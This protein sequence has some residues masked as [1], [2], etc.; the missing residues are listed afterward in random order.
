MKS[1]MDAHD[2]AQLQICGA[3][4]RF[5]FVGSAVVQCQQIA[6]INL[7]ATFCKECDHLA[8]PDCRRLAVE[9]VSDDEYRSVGCR[10]APAGPVVI[11]ELLYQAERLKNRHMEICRAANII[12][13]D[14]DMRQY[15]IFHYLNAGQHN[16]I[17]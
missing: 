5:A 3:K 4:T 9:W 17:T 1:R 14:G 15:R 11:G 12:H 10:M 16:S 6:L 2:V 7:R 8:V 13:A